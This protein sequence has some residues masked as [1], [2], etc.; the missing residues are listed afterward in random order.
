MSRETTLHMKKDHKPKQNF[1]KEIGMT[2]K[3]TLPPCAHSVY[4]RWRSER[5]YR[6]SG[7]TALWF[8]WQSTFSNSLSYEIFHW[9]ESFT[10]AWGDVTKY[11]SLVYIVGD[12]FLVLLLPYF[13]N[14]TVW[15]SATN[16]PRLTEKHWGTGERRGK[17]GGNNRQ[18][19]P[20]CQS[21]SPPTNANHLIFI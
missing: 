5:G 15:N 17:R 21:P 2:S 16:A 9:S 20:C 12:L 6:L 18:G 10:A 3:V 14:N 8:L 19:E 7:L 4:L 1:L 13:T 11:L